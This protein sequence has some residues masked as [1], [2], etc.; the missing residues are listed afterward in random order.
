M[1]FNAT[2]LSSPATGLSGAEAAAAMAALGNP[3]RLRAF[4]LIAEAGSRGLN[5]GALQGLL[6]TPASTLNHHLNT[7]VRAG[8]VRQI[9]RG[10]EIINVADAERIEDLAVFLKSL[11]MPALH[12]AEAA[13]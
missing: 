5:V 12:L 7:L 2:P 1:L 6:Q 11:G 3:T 13:S 4:R 8:I 9:R 10:R